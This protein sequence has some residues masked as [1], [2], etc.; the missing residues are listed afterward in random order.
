MLSWS[1]QDTLC[2]G[3]G[4]HLVWNAVM[5]LPGALLLVGVAL[6]AL[7]EDKPEDEAQSGLGKGPQAG[8]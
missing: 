8:C 7:Q 6:F 1:R 3:P 2:S 5:G 4:Q